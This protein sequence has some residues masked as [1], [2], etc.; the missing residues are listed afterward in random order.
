MKEAIKE[1]EK[2]YVEDEIP[3]G[4]VVVLN[5]KIIGR[6]H[7]TTEKIKDATAHAEI[8][9]ITSAMQTIGRKY[10]TGATIY[11]TLE[12]CLMCYGALQLARVSEVFCGAKDNNKGFSKY[13]YD[14]NIKTNFGILEN[15]CSLI[16]KKFFRNIRE[17][18]LYK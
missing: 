18:K 7:N 12:P 11:T 15:E 17:D 5:N 9:A 14:K 3:I 13:I 1:A 6:G 16:I 2:A 10:I 4:S 8:I